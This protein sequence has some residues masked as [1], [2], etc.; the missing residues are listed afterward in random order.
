MTF[1]G[2]RLSLHPGAASTYVLAYTPVM[3]DNA[4]ILTATIDTYSER[5]SGTEVAIPQAVLA[6]PSLGV[7]R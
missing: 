6:V 5:H 4:R 1:L 7:L 2:F 3:A